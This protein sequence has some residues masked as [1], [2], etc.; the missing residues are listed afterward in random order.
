MIYDKEFA[1]V[2]DPDTYERLYNRRKS[3]GPYGIWG[4][5]LEELSLEIIRYN[6]RTKTVQIFIG[7]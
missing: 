5:Y 6:P 2:G 1:E 7:S 4:H 3:N